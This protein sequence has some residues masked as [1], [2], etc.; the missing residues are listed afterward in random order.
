MHAAVSAERPRFL[1]RDSAD[2]G[3]LRR[4]L[5]THWSL[6]HAAFQVDGLHV[7]HSQRAQDRFVRL[8]DAC[9]C[10]LGESLAAVTL[11]VSSIRAWTSLTSGWRDVAG[12]VAVTLLAGL[13]GKGLQ[14]AWTRARLLRVLRGLRRLLGAPEGSPERDPVLAIVAPAAASSVHPASQ[15]EAADVARNN[16][17]RRSLQLDR[18]RQPAVVLRDAADS[19]RMALRLATSWKP[20]RIEIRIDALPLLDMQRAQARIVRFSGS[21]SYLPAAL[22]AIAV[23]LSGSLHAVWIGSQEWLYSQREDWWLLKLDWADVQ[24]VVVAALYAALVGTAL[25]KVWMRTRLLR[26]LRGLARNG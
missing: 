17:I 15:D 22:L 12:V 3:R 21:C 24:P 25:E 13:V 4:H 1:L 14:L 20:P 18:P 23:F 9:N 26:V 16:R 6:P 11:L 10:V 7:V 19:R 5:L 2:L 8:A